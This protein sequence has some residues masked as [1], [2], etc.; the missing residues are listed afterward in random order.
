MN[1]R[2]V[3][4]IGNLVTFPTIS[5]RDFGLHASKQDLTEI[6][7][8]FNLVDL[9]ITLARINLYLQRSD[10]ITRCENTLREHFCPQIL[11]NAIKSSEKLRGRV[12]FNRMSTLRLLSE[13]VRIANLESDYFSDTVV[14]VNADLG[15]CYL[16][17]N[18]LDHVEAA[19]VESNST[20]QK[21]EE[22]L[23]GFIPSWEY[24]INTSPWNLI[25]KSLVRVD[26]FLSRLQKPTATLS[27]NE[28]FFE[29][30]G[31]TLRD[32]QHLIFDMLCVPLTFNPAEIAGGTVG[33]IN[34]KPS[35]KL[36]PLYDKLLQHA[37]ISIDN[38]AIEAK[39][40]PSL[41]NEFLLWRKYPLVKI[42]ETQIMCIDIGFLM[43][44]LETGVFWIIRN[45]L[46]EKQKGRE[47]EIFNLR[48]P[49]FEDYVA[50]IVRR[51]TDSQTPSTLE[52]SIINPRYYRGVEGE[53][54][55][56]AVFT[57]ETLILMECK[58]P[59]LSAQTLFSG[60]A[61]K[62][63]HDLKDKVIDPKGIKQLWNAIHT[64]FH[65]DKKKRRKV[66]GI[67]IS[68]KKKIYPVL[69][70]SDRVFSCPCMNKFLDLEFQRFVRNTALTD[71]PEIMPLTVLTIEDLESL[72][73]F[74]SDKPLY[75][76]LDNWLTIFDDNKSYPFSQYLNSFMDKELRENTH[77][78]QE[79]ERILSEI[80]LYFSAHGLE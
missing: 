46:G 18:E 74:L 73:P 62:F 39:G 6:L 7:R 17:A 28:T 15:R 3:L 52:T 69:V 19:N 5:A 57:Q 63:Y 56:I 13:S 23:V 14:D 30:T 43:D 71:G 58:A 70:L 2:N 79:C 59:L 54:T 47:K 20:D 26:D 75:E 22:L 78:D 60:D 51:S 37:C 49:V 76:H 44:K 33:F 34:T 45:Q 64:L 67:R 9:V 66:D 10:N 12:I 27:A 11:L 4:R 72:E 38:L 35:P 29:A 65:T 77:I 61:S 40:T 25:K 24:A 21:L 48:G 31:L 42:N 53:C 41:P 32:Y 16:I 8:S 80:K 36:A 55:D 68:G 1:Q 50:S